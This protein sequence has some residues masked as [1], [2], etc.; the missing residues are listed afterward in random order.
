MGSEDG[1]EVPE[2]M[3]KLRKDLEKMVKLFYQLKKE[4]RLWWNRRWGAEHSHYLPGPSSPVNGRLVGL[5]APKTAFAWIYSQ[6]V[7]KLYREAHLR[8]SEDAVSQ[9]SPRGAVMASNRNLE[10]KIAV[11]LK[12]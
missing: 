7:L 5:L 3:G 4:I 10:W 11:D 9:R 12:T 8:H 1:C 6:S 2:R